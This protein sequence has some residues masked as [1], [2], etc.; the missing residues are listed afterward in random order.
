MSASY[1]NIMSVPTPPDDSARSER[2][3][4]GSPQPMDQSGAGAERETDLGPPA[5]VI[6]T[7]DVKVKE[8]LKVLV[9]YHWFGPYFTVLKTSTSYYV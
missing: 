4:E 7:D 1:D 6:S 3:V 8:L 9:Q 5:V 2:D